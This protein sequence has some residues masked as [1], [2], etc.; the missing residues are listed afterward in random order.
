[1][2]GGGAPRLARRS[3]RAAQSQL[4]RGCTP[5]CRVPL[6]R[7][8]DHPRSATCAQSV[9]SMSLTNCILDFMH[10]I[11]RSTRI[12]RRLGCHVIKTVT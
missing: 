6:M 11:I 1:M 2:G 8:A 3:S 9:P 10:A 12:R 7:C 5:K 4:M